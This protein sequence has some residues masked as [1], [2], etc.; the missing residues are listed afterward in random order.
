MKKT[1]FSLLTLLTCFAFADNC[2]ICVCNPCECP[3]PE[4]TPCPPPSTCAYNAPYGIDLLCQWD[5]F[6]TGSFI[7]LEPKQDNMSL[8]YFA[9]QI[10]LSGTDEQPDEQRIVSTGSDQPNYT[11]KP[12]FKVGLGV[13][14]DCDSWEVYAEY[15][16]H[17]SKTVSSMN[18]AASEF[19][20]ANQ[21]TLNYIVPDWLFVNVVSTVV[22]T[23]AANANLQVGINKASQTWKL[24][25]DVADFELARQYYVGRCLTFRT[26]GGL[27][28]AWIRQDV[29]AV[30]EDDPATTIATGAPGVTTSTSKSKSWAVG[31]RIG[32]DTNWMFCQGFKFYMDTSASILFTKYTTNS[33]TAERVL[34]DTEVVSNSFSYTPTNDLC[35]LRP[36][37]DIE[38][39]LGW[40]DYFF[41]NKWFFGLDIGYVFQVYFNENMFYYYTPSSTTSNAYQAITPRN[42]NLYLHGLVVSARLDF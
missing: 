34:Y 16:Y 22:S 10:M 5:I 2:N 18:A 35:Y 38:L 27:R 25:L 20:G 39:G 12:G 1:L 21:N 23:N 9:Q 19:A 17:H 40:G 7:W 13:N 33:I 14:F 31:P 4:F 36:Q 6:L 11:Y 3:C 8:G 42:G 32:L 29:E 24:N 28:G 37:F 30:Y 26:S 41:C 15:M